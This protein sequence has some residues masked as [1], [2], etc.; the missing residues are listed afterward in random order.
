MT[1]TI[2]SLEEEDKNWLDEEAERTG[3]PMAVIVRTAIHHLR[4]EKE[5][6]LSS[7][8]KQTSGTWGEGDGLAWQKR[9]RS[10]WD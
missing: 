3:K 9:L 4:E 6:A 8:L 5:R 10:E 7:L 2:I 1:R